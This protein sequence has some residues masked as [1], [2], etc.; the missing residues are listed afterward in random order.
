MDGRNLLD[1]DGDEGEFSISG[2]VQNK[3]TARFKHLEIRDAQLVIAVAVLLFVPDD[4]ASSG[5]D[6]FYRFALQ[7]RAIARRMETVVIK[8][9]KDNMRRLTAGKTVFIGAI[10]QEVKPIGN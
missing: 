6:A 1:T 4:D 5:M 2:S 7:D 10:A 9:I 3:Y 8:D